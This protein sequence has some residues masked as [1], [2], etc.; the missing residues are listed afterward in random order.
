MRVEGHLTPY[1]FLLG[2]IIEEGVD[3]LLMA[4]QV[5]GIITDIDITITTLSSATKATVLLNSNQIASVAAAGFPTGYPVGINARGLFIPIYQEEKIEI[6][7]AGLA[8]DTTGYNISGY[9]YSVQA[10][11][12]LDVVGAG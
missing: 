7:V 8:G 9:L 1:R 12:G 6:D 11:Y 5:Q 10:A 3:T 2:T 4:A